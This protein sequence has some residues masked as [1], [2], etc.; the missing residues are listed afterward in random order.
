MNPS[1][2]SPRV[3]AKCRFNG[4]RFEEVYYKATI[5]RPFHTHEEAFLDF[6]LEGTIQ[7]FWG[8]QT[9]LRG[10]STL[11]FLPIGAPHANRF[12][13]DVRTLQIVMSAPWLARVGQ[14]APLVET[15]TSYS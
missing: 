1:L 4:L 12:P 15:L 3:E 11:N 10:P 6:C 9:F 5:Y 8:K 7:E 13:D 2:I 14:T